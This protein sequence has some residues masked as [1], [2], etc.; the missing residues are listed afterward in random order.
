MKV[1]EL[2]N[3]ASDCR[4]HRDRSSRGPQQ[5]SLRWAYQARVA[6]DRI[7]FAIKHT[8]RFAEPC[9]H[10]R[11][12][13]PATVGCAG[14]ARILGSALSN[15]IPSRDRQKR[16]RRRHKAMNRVQRLSAPQAAVEGFLGV[17]CGST[18]IHKCAFDGHLFTSPGTEVPG[19]RA[20]GQT[21]APPLGSFPHQRRLRVL[22]VRPRQ[23]GDRGSIVADIW[24]T[25]GVSPRSLMTLSG[26]FSADGP[27]SLLIHL[28]LCIPV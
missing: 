4:D 5:L 10:V 3:H 7:K 2:R 13:R 19:S 25:F 26:E 24:R 6:I 12:G 1:Y 16:N 9:I 21:F 23:L 17:L 15:S 14:P 8:E 20:F 18:S 22:A 11:R 27:E 28:F